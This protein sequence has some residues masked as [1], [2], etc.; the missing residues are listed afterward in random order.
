M[1]ARIAYREAFPERMSKVPLFALS[2]PPPSLSS[3]PA[4]KRLEEGEEE[5]REGARVGERE[6]EGEREKEVYG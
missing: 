4:T 2:R 6:R 5:D 1:A 3:R